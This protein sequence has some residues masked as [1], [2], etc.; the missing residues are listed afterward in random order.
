VNWVDLVV[1]GVVVVSAAHALMRGFVR[2]VLGIF[3]W[4]GA[5]WFAMV[6]YEY[7]APRFHTWI[8]EPDLADAAAYGA[9]FLLALVFL[10]VITGMLGHFVH[11][12]GLG[13]LDRTL[14]VAYGTLRGVVLV[15]AAYVAAG[16][17]APVQRWPDPVL[18]ARLLPY[19]YEAAAWC[20]E[21]LPPHFRPGV[22]V[23]PTGR[24]TRAADLLRATP[25]GRAQ[26][27]PVERPAGGL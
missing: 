18:E 2:E 7:V 13:G 19:V 26:D 5:I 23:P 20:A 15:L 17:V 1:I 22:P 8:T 3:A 25:Q 24:D 6:S 16:W 14:G 9:M 21:Q 4:G 11:T 10:S 12:S 27:R